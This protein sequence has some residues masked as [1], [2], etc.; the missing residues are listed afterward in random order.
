M[1]FHNSIQNYGG[2]GLY[3]HRL[4]VSLI[5]P[6]VKNTNNTFISNVGETRFCMDHR[7]FFL[8]KRIKT[9][10]GDST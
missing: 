5:D 9:F 7:I 1:A 2:G 8:I 4:L 10:V 6:D 3:L